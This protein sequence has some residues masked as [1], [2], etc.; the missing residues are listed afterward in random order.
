MGTILLG[1]VP[2]SDFWSKS[3]FHWHCPPKLINFCKDGI[4][5]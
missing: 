3:Q 4:T 5:R 1:Q 2:Q